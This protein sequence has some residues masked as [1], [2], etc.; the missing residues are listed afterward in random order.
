ML[1]RI[2][3]EW[4]YV[5]VFFQY[6]IIEGAAH[7]QYID[8]I[9]HVKLLAF[10]IVLRSSITARNPYHTT[11]YM[12]TTI[13]SSLY[14]QIW[15]RQLVWTRL[16]WFT[17]PNAYAYVYIYI[18][19][20]DFAGHTFTIFTHTHARWWSSRV[21]WCDLVPLGD[22]SYDTLAIDCISRV[23]CLPPGSLIFLYFSIKKLLAKHFA[24]CFTAAF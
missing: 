14:I 21:I 11:H 1:R 10:N 8:F 19:L 17:H 6:A 5:E 18:V 16:H 2:H 4:I 7:V 22:W 23:G 3:H 15:F 20:Y 13:W 24:W 12:H 9:E